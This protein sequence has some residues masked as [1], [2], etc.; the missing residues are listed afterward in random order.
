MSGWSEPLL[1]AHTTF[2]EISCRGTFVI[3]ESNAHYQFTI[4]SWTNQIYRII[5]IT[6]FLWKQPKLCLFRYILLK[7]RFHHQTF[8]TFI[9]IIF[10]RLSNLIFKLDTALEGSILYLTKNKFVWKH[11]MEICKITF[12]L[13]KTNFC[14]CKKSTAFFMGF[15]IP[16]FFSNI[17]SRDGEELF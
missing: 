12:F 3:I 2:L 14:I 11:N 15:R 7:T 6:E 4:I 8:T 16:F 5:R 10:R 1:V 17:Y 9:C 13:L